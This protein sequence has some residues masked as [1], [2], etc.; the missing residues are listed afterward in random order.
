MAAGERGVLVLAEGR[1]WRD[2]G[3]G[4]E[5]L[6]DFDSD[7][8]QYLV[9][10]PDG[11]NGWA[12]GK[13][14]WST[15][16]GGRTWQRTNPPADPMYGYHVWP[17][18]TYV[19]VQTRDHQNREQYFRAAPGADDWTPVDLPEG[20]LVSS[21]HAVAVLSYVGEDL[22]SPLL[23]VSVDDATTWRDLSLP[24]SGENQLYPAEAE[25]F[26]L[27]SQ[28][29]VTNAYRTEDLATWK[30]FGSVKGAVSDVEVVGPSLLVVGAHSVLVGADGSRQ[31][32]TDLGEGAWDVATVGSTSYLAS[33]D[34]RLLVSRDGGLTW[35]A[36]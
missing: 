32:V 35:S 17:T 19:W 26:V 4:W 28:G 24:C 33:Q 31:V 23:R 1:V 3:S 30:A 29:A 14:L 2:D 16:D 13:R 8:F 18:S 11:V 5:L 25:F 27:C 21:E 12:W 9:M 7:D 22:S 15:H 36:Q 6:H 10:A 34:G 20:S